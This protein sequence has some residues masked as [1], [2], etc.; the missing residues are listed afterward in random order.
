MWFRRIF[1]A[2]APRLRSKGLEADPRSEG[3]HLSSRALRQLNHLK[4]DTGRFIPG[5]AMGMR[6][7]QRRQP[8]ADFREHR[9]YAPGDDARF[10]DWKAS[11]RQEHIFIKQGEHLK[12]ATVYI[13]VDTSASMTWGDPPKSLSVLSLAAALGYLAL[14]H[15]DRLVVAP[16]TTR[17]TDDSPQNRAFSGPPLGPITGKGQFPSVLNYLRA[18]PFRGQADFQ[19]SL[20]GIHHLGAA[21][22]GLALILTDLMDVEDL[23]RGLERLPA[24]TWS[25]AVFHL[26]H[27]EEIDPGL[28]GDFM[29]QDIETGRLK[30]CSVTPKTLE[31]YKERL[32]A[33]QQGIQETCLEKKAFYTMIPTSWTL[34]N[35][36]LPYLLGAHVVS[37]L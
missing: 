37:P 22:G 36:I 26:L 34:E 1:N 16:L 4:L 29:M 3:L 11:A 17:G 25:T 2:K 27:P 31:I 35:E 19:R 20:H 12:E 30:K 7:S 24:P 21:R 10:V 6:S 28:R 33:W 32:Q 13:L 23:S 14:S 18:L 8:A 15:G 5:Y 9:M